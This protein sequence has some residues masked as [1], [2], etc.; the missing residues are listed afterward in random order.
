MLKTYKIERFA[1][2]FLFLHVAF[3]VFLSYFN[4]R[5]FEGTYVREGGFIEW[6]TVDVL[7]FGAL[8]CLYRAYRAR[9]KRG[10]W[11]FLCLILMAL[12]FIF[13]AGEELS[14]GQRIFGFD[15]PAFFKAMNS[16]QE[17]NIHNL[18]TKGGFKVNKRI[19]GLGLG[20]CVVLYFLVLPLLYN[21]VKFITKFVEKC[22][23]P[24][25]RLIHIISYIA[26]F[27]LVEMTASG[28]KGELLE[29]GGVW[30]F[31]LMILFPKNKEIFHN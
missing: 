23:L 2:M 30:I 3:G 20:I 24:I 26:L 27:L 11:F 22:A 8:L 7:V 15:S 9:F 18:V 6:L 21:R 29:F 12:L 16:Q 14:W 13:G 31:Y 10:A 17:T 25:P 4:V 19:F 28:K 5:Y 1:I